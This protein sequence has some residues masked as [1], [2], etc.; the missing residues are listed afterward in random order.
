MYE[1]IFS[2]STIYKFRENEIQWLVMK[3][4]IRL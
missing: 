4:K 2:T 1:N 3:V